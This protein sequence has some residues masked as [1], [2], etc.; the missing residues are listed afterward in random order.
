MG[1]SFPPPPSGGATGI[2]NIRNEMS[3]LGPYI[4]YKRTAFL[5]CCIAV[6]LGIW[7]RVMRNVLKLRG[8]MLFGKSFNAYWHES[9]KPLQYYCSCLPVSILLPMKNLLSI[10]EGPRDASCQ[11]KSCQLPS[12]SAVRQ[13]L[14]KSKLWSWRVKVGGCIVNMCTQPWRVRVT[15]IV[16]QVS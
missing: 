6:K 10:A 4:W 12:N 8:R 14:N 15:F 13:V 5:L 7:V 11:L 2:D 1:G 3:A 16:L 9:V